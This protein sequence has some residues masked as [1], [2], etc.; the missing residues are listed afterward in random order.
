[1]T[2]K[3]NIIITLASAALLLVASCQKVIVTVEKGIGVFYSPLGYNY[4]G[5]GASIPGYAPLIFE[6][7]VVEKP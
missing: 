5:S 4:S 3:K 6:I 2:M 1:M 7:E